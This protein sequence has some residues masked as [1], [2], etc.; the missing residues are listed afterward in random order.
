MTR[1][2]TSFLAFAAFAVLS[3][4]QPMEEDSSYHAQQNQPVAPAPVCQ[5]AF[6]P[7]GGKVIP[8]TVPPL[9]VGVNT[10]MGCSVKYDAP[11]VVVP[12]GAFNPVC[13]ALPAGGA[14]SIVVSCQGVPANPVVPPVSAL[15]LSFTC[16]CPPAVGLGTNNKTEVYLF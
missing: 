11:P 14:N 5:F 1:Y 9:K 15:G 8:G 12:A 13:L 16:S 3:A 2:L 7:P 4:C 6:V 10:N